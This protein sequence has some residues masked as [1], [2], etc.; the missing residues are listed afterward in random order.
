MMEKR[1][2]EEVLGDIEVELMDMNIMSAMRMLHDPTT[3]YSDRE[4][5]YLSGFADIPFDEEEGEEE[6]DETP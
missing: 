3:N 4:Q 5:E 6:E 2:V 1:S